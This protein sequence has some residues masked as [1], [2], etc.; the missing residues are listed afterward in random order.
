[1]KKQRAGKKLKRNFVYLNNLKELLSCKSEAKTAEDAQTLEYLELCLQVRACYH[2]DTTYTLLQESNATASEKTND[3]FAIEVERASRNHICY[4]MFSLTIDAFKAKQ[5]KD[6]GVK[7]VLE[8]LLKVFALKQILSDST[9]L[10][11]S[12]FFGRGDSK[13]LEG[14]LDAQLKVM[15]P[16]MIS[17]VE[18][19]DDSSFNKTAAGNKYGD[20]YEMMLDYAKNS[21]L[22]KDPIPSYY[23]E[24]MK[25][26]I[27]GNGD[28]GKF[29]L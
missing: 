25:P 4:M 17:L 16:Q 8:N 21:E 2:L 9:G 5:F 23:T 20:I 12:G 19:V 22:N 26:I 6:P 3:I 27:H 15:R 14:A 13:L 28:G 11:D 10:Y 24:Y 7:A 18:L 1:M 29:K